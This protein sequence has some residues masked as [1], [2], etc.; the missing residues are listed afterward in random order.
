MIKVSLQSVRIRV[1]EHSKVE[2]KVQSTRVIAHVHSIHAYH[3]SIPWI[4]DIVEAAEELLV[5]VRPQ[6]RLQTRRDSSVIV[7]F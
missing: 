1:I 6:F 4:D 7:S 5:D 3:R 2:W